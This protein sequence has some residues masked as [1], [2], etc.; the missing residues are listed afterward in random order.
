LT[1]KGL[2]TPERTTK[3]RNEAKNMVRDALKNAT[4]EL[5]PPVDSLFED[6]YDEMPLHLQE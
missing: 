4:G 5:L 6:V 1:R 2:I 3:L